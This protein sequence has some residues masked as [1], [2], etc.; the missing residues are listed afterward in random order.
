MKKKG[1]TIQPIIIMALGVLTAILVILIFKQ[2]A[3][4]GSLQTYSFGSGLLPEEEAPGL[5][6]EIEIPSSL[7]SDFESLVSNINNAKD[8]DSCLVYASELRIDS[9][10]AIR[11]S[12][13]KAEILRDSGTGGVP[14]V[15]ERR[16][17]VNFKPCELKNEPVIKFYNCHFKNPE[18]CADLSLP[19]EIIELKKDE[20]FKFLYNSGGNFCKFKFYN[21]FWDNGPLDSTCRFPRDGGRDGIGNSCKD[22]I[23]NKVIKC[24][25]K[26]EGVFLCDDDHCLNNPPTKPWRK[27]TTNLNNICGIIPDPNDSMPAREKI[28]GQ[29]GSI[30]IMGPYDVRLYENRN[31]GGK[32]IC[33]RD[34]GGYRLDNY[35]LACF[36]GICNGWNEDTDSVEILPDNTCEN[37]GVTS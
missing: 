30:R 13:G 20:E 7:K 2:R 10:W 24:G 25:V 1:I 14:T 4:A 27:T 26:F 29:A 12:E 6:G 21:D 37:Q 18:S 3:S 9:G 36:L 22:D 16:P 15:K 34:E 33:F 23:E 17:L 35:P 32:K 5:L 28:C 11:L 31:Y 19:Q 8:T